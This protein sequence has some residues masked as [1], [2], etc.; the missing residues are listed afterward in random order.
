[1]KQIMVLSEESGMLLFSD[2]YVS[3]SQD[4][5][6]SSFP[7][8]DIQNANNQNARGQVSLETLQLSS[9]LFALYKLSHGCGVTEE[10]SLKWL[11][12]VYTFHVF[13]I[14]MS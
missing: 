13:Y 7:S 12:K 6:S 5:S 10:H 8:T 4:P 3:V 9:S 11:L 2:T 1:M 14:R